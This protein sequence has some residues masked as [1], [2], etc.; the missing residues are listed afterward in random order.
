MPVGVTV[1]PDPAPGLPTPPP[2]E[3]G[4]S[5]RPPAS[6]YRDDVTTIL[7]TGAR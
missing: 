2:H 3:L 6:S 7:A 4:I 5:R 1:R